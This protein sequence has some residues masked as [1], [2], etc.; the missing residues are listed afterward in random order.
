[1]NREKKVSLPIHIIF[2]TNKQEEKWGGLHGYE[3]D[4]Q[5]KS[6][7]EESICSARINGFTSAARALQSRECRTQQQG[8][9]W[10]PQ[11]QCKHQ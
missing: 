3:G 4:E 2:P 11:R 5:K 6:A 10:I 7:A 9:P 8:H 1:M